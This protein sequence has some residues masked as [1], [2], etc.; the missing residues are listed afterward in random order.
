MVGHVD[1]FGIGEE[2]ATRVSAVVRFA[3]ARAHQRGPRALRRSH[4]HSRYPHF[5][6]VKTRE[7][8]TTYP[9]MFFFSAWMF[10]RRR[11]TV[12]SFQSSGMASAATAPA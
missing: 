2:R 10:H 11:S 8:M 1:L 6:N 3:R 9:T 7:R 4:V 12:V 5:Q